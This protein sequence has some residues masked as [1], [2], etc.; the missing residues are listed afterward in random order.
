MP[1]TNISVSATY[2]TY[3]IQQAGISYHPAVPLPTTIAAVSAAAAAPP[4]PP[5]G[6][7]V[8]GFT[9]PGSLAAANT[10]ANSGTL[11]QRSYPWTT[12]FNMNPSSY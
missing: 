10:V 9:I 7:S 2:P 11:V 1:V 4:P 5:A 6:I 3:T 12:G 8:P